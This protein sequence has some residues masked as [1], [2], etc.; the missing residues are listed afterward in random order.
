M[1][2]SNRSPYALQYQRWRDAD[3]WPCDPDAYQVERLIGRGA[4]ARVYMARCTCNAMQRVA[5]K[6]L[7]LDDVSAEIS[8]IMKEVQMMR[9]CCHVNILCCHAS[10]VDDSDLILVMPLMEKGSCQHVMQS[11]KKQ[12]LCEGM[13]EEWIGY[14]LLEVLH[15]LKYLHDN[16]HIHRDI[17]AGNVLLDPDGKVALAD[18]GVSSW[19]VHGGLRQRKA[20][21][22]VGTPYVVPHWHISHE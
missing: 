4:F 6:M 8:N 11:A 10:F 9:M 22:F 21:T 18:F 5:L 2:D 15:G 7:D 12:G 17:K 13:A 3:V 14:I 19:L 1:V 16:G 20:Q